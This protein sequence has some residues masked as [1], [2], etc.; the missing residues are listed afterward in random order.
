MMNQRIRLRRSWLVLSA[1]CMGVMTTSA[2]ADEEKAHRFEADIQ[3]FEAQ[4]RRSPPPEGAI[5]FVGSSSIRLWNLARSF[6]QWKVINRGFGGS[7]VADSLYFAD[8]IVTK[9][10]PRAIVFYA[11][12]NDL[13]RGTPVEQVVTD[14][15]EFLAKVHAALPQTPVVFIAIKPSPSRAKLVNKQR[16]VNAQVSQL[17]KGD[18]LLTVVDAWATMADADGNPRSDIFLPDG[19]HLN[20]KGYEIWAPLVTDALRKFE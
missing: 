8:R 5:L 10:K 12:D 15:R 6:P 3:K 16:E 2:R 19:L 4:D 7:L 20:A 11:G 14:F 9:Y 17:A 13:A 18:P 1:L